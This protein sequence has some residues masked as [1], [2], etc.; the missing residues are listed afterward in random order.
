MEAQ[1][2]YPQS[3][4]RGY[5]AFISIIAALG[6]FLFGFDT[7][8]VSGTIQFLR[9]LFQ[10]SATAEGWVVASALV[11]CIG[12]ASIAGVSSDA[13]GRKPALIIAAA[14]FLLS[15]IG[16]TLPQSV[17]ALVAARIVGGVGVGMASMLSPLY[18]SEMSPPHLRGRLVALYQLT[19]TVGILVAYFSNASLQYLASG[20]LSSMESGWLR[21]ILVDQVWRA[22]FATETVP[23]AAFLL[24]LLFIP[25]S[26]R[27]LAAQGR[28]ERARANLT[29]IAG[30][31]QAE[32]QMRDIHQALKQ[33]NAALS[34]LLRP[35]LRVALLIGLLLPF[36]GQMTGINAII[37]YGTTIFEEAGW[38]IG[39]ALGGQAY[40]GLVN[41]VF[42][43]VAI[44]TVDYFGRKPL[45]YVG[46]TGL[47]ATLVTAGVLFQINV[48]GWPLL[49]V[50]MLFV[51]CFA[52]S[53]GPLPWILIAEIF[54]NRIRGRAMS[55]GTL[56]VWLTNTAVSQTFPIMRDTFGP[57]WTFWTFAVCVAPVLLL[58]FFAI[59]E[60]KGRTLEQIE[61][62]WLDQTETDTPVAEPASSPSS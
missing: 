20:A 11:G 36:F 43:F 42:T 17:T 32:H 18:L 61:Q 15:A 19:I 59:P 10:L 25:E 27:W 54:P 48:T 16:S 31:A 49:V 44:A 60:T 35:G 21:W 45:L 8:V 26:T 7:A 55:L 3:G 53:L 52:F 23:A 9:D 37:Y 40:I 28:D 34:E 50:L 13:F 46:A 41:C 29:R 57:A 1:R 6:G 12:G 22:M 51:A 56:V 38:T 30:P 47:I 24:L 39:N 4:S 58:A 62:D 14:L 33:E 2:Q 5:L